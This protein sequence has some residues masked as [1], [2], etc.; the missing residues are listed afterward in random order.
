MRIRMS[1]N[2]FFNKLADF[3]IL[4]PIFW[5]FTGLFHLYNGDKILVVLTLISALVSV[6]KYKKSA[7]VINIKSKYVWLMY[8]LLFI[9]ITAD[10]LSIYNPINIRAIAILCV[11]LTF[12]PYQLITRKVLIFSCFIGCINALLFVYH[13]TYIDPVNRR[14]WPINAIP[15]ATYICFISAIVFILLLTSKMIKGKIILSLTLVIS[16][17]SLAIT[18]TRGALVALLP[19]LISIYFYYA[20]QRKTLKKSIVISLISTTLIFATVYPVI[21]ERIIGTYQEITQIDDGNTDTSIGLRLNFWKAGINLIEQSPFFGYG[22]NYYSQ[23][24]QLAKEKVIIQ[25]AANYKPPHFHNQFID[26]AVKCGLLG[27]TFLLVLLFTPI[28]F[29]RNKYSLNAL[30]IYSFISILILS[31]L[32]DVPFFHKQ[33]FIIYFLCVGIFLSREKFES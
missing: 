19:T 28:Y 26:I 32:T 3:L 21:K 18:E 12:L 2:K 22:H 17:M 20:Y 11:F 29:V 31:G 27:L 33:I 14:F 10:I 6:I 7:I 23:L 25:A 1:S 15:F 24:N 5:S 8:S 13:F 16:I 30:C 4:L 9:S